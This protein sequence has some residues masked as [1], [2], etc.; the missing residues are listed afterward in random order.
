MLRLPEP[1][2]EPPHCSQGTDKLFW[3]VFLTVSSCLH[4]CVCMSAPLPAPFNPS[5][6]PW[7]LPGSPCA[8]AT[9]SSAGL[10]ASC[11]RLTRHW[12]RWSSGS[13][14]RACPQ[15]PC[16]AWR[17]SRSSDCPL[18]CV[19]A[20]AAGPAGRVFV[21]RCH[22]FFLRCGWRC[23]LPLLAGAAAARPKWPQNLPPPLLPASTPSSVQ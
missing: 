13:S 16:L 21:D 20:T 15:G 6:P 7:H 12:M 17:V 8:G 5:P 22:C 1:Y 19:A 11:R 10:A 18:L 3:N 14:C 23:R 2:L 9:A 4:H